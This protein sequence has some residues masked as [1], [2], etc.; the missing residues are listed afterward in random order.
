[1]IGLDWIS[2]PT[3]QPLIRLFLRLGKKLET[4]SEGERPE[5]LFSLSRQDVHNFRLWRIF[6]FIFLVGMCV[7][8]EIVLAPESKVGGMCW[9]VGYVTVAWYEI[10]ST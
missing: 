10:M 4:W 1:M 3:N 5:Y 9:L 8:G 6:Y 7:F 2:L